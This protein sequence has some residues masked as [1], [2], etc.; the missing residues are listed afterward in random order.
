MPPASPQRWIALHA[1][2]GDALRQLL[3]VAEGSTRADPRHVDERL[4]Q[5]IWQDQLLAG[6]KLVTSS[7]KRAE[8]IEAGR[9]NTGRGPDFLD[10]R[11]RL[12]GEE[13]RGDIEIHIHSG[14]WTN[15]GHH[16]DFE[17]NNVVLHVCLQ[18]R[19]DRPY[20]EKQNGQRLERLVISHF[21]EPDLDTIRRTINVSDYPYGR[22][23]DLGLCHEQFIKLPES[24]MREFFHTAGMAR[25]EDKIARFQTQLASASPQQLIYQSI[26]TGQ[27]Y[28]SNKTLY[29]LLSKRAP[30]A[31]LLDY[32]GDVGPA[33][34][35]DLFLS[36][37]LH[38]ANLFPADATFPAETD[39]ATAAFVRR[40]EEQWRPVRAYFGDRLIP[41]TK[42][43]FSGMRPP[44]F[45]GRRLAAVAILLTRLADPVLPLFDSICKRL[46]ELP[47]NALN[48]KDWKLL[49][50]Q[51]AESLSVEG[52]GHYF[53][54]HYTLGGKP[55]N[56]QALLGEPAARTLL[57]NVI[58]PLAILRA[59]REN[60]PAL[61]Q[62]ALLA[63]ERFPAL[64]KNSV[65]EFMRHRLFGESGFDKALFGTELMQ[66]ALFKIFN[67]C[68]SQNERTC[69]SCSFLNPPYEPAG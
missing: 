64:P 13:L 40:I 30:Y 17:Y 19:D 61:E 28:K 15:H 55:C 65:T 47:A 35:T 18:A 4:V 24:R 36:I 54:T 33:A 21:L 41:P 26:M 38:V 20:E 49:F 63:A 69:D 7:G 42:R 57:F 66:Q 45:P 56:A 27:G 31:E 51:L 14:D 32:A 52:E 10:A 6:E 25:I 29:F 46:R 9:W 1:E 67:D 23:A 48:A 59:R 39:D 12:A 5:C 11:V 50:T 8:V 43:W 2:F 37:M 3:R 44:G 60:D 22:P 62:N 58:L 34:R 53:N 68:C 16:Q